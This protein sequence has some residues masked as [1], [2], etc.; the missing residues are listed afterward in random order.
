[1]A[2]A[3]WF[4]PSSFSLLTSRLLPSSFDTSS[5]LCPDQH[6]FATHRHVVQHERG[7]DA[8][9]FSGVDVQTVEVEAVVAV[10]CAVGEEVDL[11]LA[12]QQQPEG[13]REVDDAAVVGIPG[14][15]LEA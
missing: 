1:M 12:H 15:N 4:L 3:S 5:S 7:T 14:E 6:P 13:Q 8:F 10:V 2:S 9:K 11:A